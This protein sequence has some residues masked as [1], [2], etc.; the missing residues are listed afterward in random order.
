MSVNFRIYEL[1]QV[2]ARSNLAVVSLIHREGTTDLFSYRSIGRNDGKK[3]GEAVPIFYRK[4]RFSLSS[5]RHFWLSPTPEVP[6][7]KGWDAGQPRMVTIARLIDLHSAAR[8]EKGE[9]EE[10]IVA[11]THWDDRGLEARTESAKL[12]LELLDNESKNVTREENGKQPLVVLLGDLNS[13]AEEAGYQTLTGG[14]YLEKKIS[15]DDKTFWDSRHEIATRRTSLAGP[16]ALS[17]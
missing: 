5:V 10:I 16:G 4:S 6:G 12:I 2:G 13:P 11:N 17:R 3:A 8:T 7:S 1:F 15:H 14:R 9:L